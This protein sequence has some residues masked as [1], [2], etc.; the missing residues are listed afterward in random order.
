MGQLNNELAL[1]VLLT[2]LKGVLILP[3]QS[4]LAAVTVDVRHSVK[5]SE[6][7]SLLGGP[8]AHV[9]YTVEQVGSA[10]AALEGFRNELLMLS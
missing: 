2:G 4:G 3:S 7:H 6:E 1:L 9:H 10:L 8:T 5:A